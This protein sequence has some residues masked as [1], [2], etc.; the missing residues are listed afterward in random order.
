MEQLVAV[1]LLWG[2]GIALTYD[3]PGR[4]LT[5]TLAAFQARLE[6]LPEEVLEIQLALIDFTEEG[7]CS[8]K[9]KSRLKQSE[10]S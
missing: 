7:N 8:N 9:H 3:P 1:L 10:K 6:K 5:D 2:A 4:N